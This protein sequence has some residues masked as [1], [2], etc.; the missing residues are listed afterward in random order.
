VDHAI[1][2]MDFGIAKSLEEVRRST[3][4]I[5]GTPYYMAPEQAAGEAVDHRADLYAFGVTLSQLLTGQLPFPDGA[6]SYRHR[7][8]DPPDPRELNLE[9]PAPLAQLILELME[10]E[11]QA[12]PASAAIVGTSLARWAAQGR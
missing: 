4:V 3:T 2:I 9:V 8:E 11:P 1:K 6:V 12:R 7:H 10:K 5:G